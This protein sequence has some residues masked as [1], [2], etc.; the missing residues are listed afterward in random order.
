M[1]NENTLTIRKNEL[2]VSS[3]RL[4]ENGVLPIGNPSFEQWQQAME[5]VQR[6]EQAVYF[7]IG[8]LLNYGETLYGETYTQAI[9]ATGF[10]YGTLANDKSVARAIPQPI[11][12]SDL[13]FE[14]HRAVAKLEP[15]DQEKWLDKASEEHWTV[16]ELRKELNGT[17]RNEN[18]KKQAV[19]DLEIAAKNFC[20]KYG[21]S[22]DELA[23]IVSLDEG[24]RVVEN[25]GLKV[26]SEEIKKKLKFMFGK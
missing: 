14:H 15:N 13:S 20:E 1:D 5:F 6:S 18:T 23:I 25:G 24:E 17:P 12:K 4:L 16:K 21:V 7:W 11:R 8:D 2:V 3:F 26:I 10:E 19:I 9:D 22:R